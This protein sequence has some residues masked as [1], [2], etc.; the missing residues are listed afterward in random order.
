M[1]IS[2]NN[3]PI[4]IYESPEGSVKVEVKVI[5]ETLW[6]SLNQIAEVFDRD[7]SVISRHLKNIYKEEELEEEATVAKF[8]TVQLEG[9]KSVERLIEH[10][11][12]DAIISVGYRVNSKRGVQFRKWASGVL[13]DY[14]IQGYSLN[15]DRILE[16]KIKELQSAIDL[17]GTTLISGGFVAGTGEGF[18][19]IIKAYSKTWDLLIKYDEERLL[20]PENLHTTSQEI[21]TYEYAMNSIKAFKSELGVEGL[22]GIERGEVFEGILGNLMQSF[23]GQDLYPSIEEKAAH[24]LYFV[25]KDHPFSDGNKRIG[26][27]L[28]LLYLKIS[29]IS[30]NK[31]NEN[32]VTALALLVA[33]SDPK[34]KDLM[35][36]LIVHILV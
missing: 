3:N 4:A 6:L 19:E 27:F 35:I 30:L 13:K 16:G 8:A 9:S 23:G 7:K 11:N 5:D 21:I 24:L 10:Y 31:M 26:S 20:T 18:V 32:T 1:S 2:T 34:Q 36:N 25:I 17:I 22:F 12:L 28:F 14:L 15:K 29:G 33:E